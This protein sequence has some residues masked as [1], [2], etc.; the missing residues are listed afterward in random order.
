MQINR[1][2]DFGEFPLRVLEATNRRNSLEMRHICVQCKYE[3]AR[4]QSAMVQLMV[5]QKYDVE[6]K[7]RPQRALQV[8]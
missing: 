4:Y 8:M 5:M 2:C 7:L 1:A 3:A 6:V